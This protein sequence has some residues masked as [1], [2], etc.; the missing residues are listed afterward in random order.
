MEKRPRHRRL[1]ALI[2]F[3][4]VLFGLF[5]ARLFQ[6]Q[7]TEGSHYASLLHQNSSLILP[8]PASRGEILDRN[9]TPLVQNRAS[10]QVMI[11]YNYYPAGGGAAQ[12]AA[13]NGI[14]LELTAILT[15]AGEDWSDSLPLSREEPYTFLP[16]RDAGVAALRETLDLP[17]DADAANCMAALVT[18]YRLENFSQPEQRIAAGVQYEMALR[19]FG[20]LSPFL[21]ASDVSK[22]TTYTIGEKAADFPGV[23]IETA[24]V[25]DIVSGDTAPQLIG[26][27]GPMYAE[28]YARLKDKGYALNDTLGKSG[29]EAAF[30]SLL[31]GQSG[32]KELTKDPAGQVIGSKDIVSPVPGQTVILTL[33]SSLQELA[34][35]AIGDEINKLHKLSAK[36]GNYHDA[37]SGAAVM[38]DVKDGGVLAAAS[39]PNYDLSTYRQNYEE[40]AADPLKP[41]F[42][43]AL[44]G[45]YPCGSAMKPNVALAALTEEVIT[46]TSTVYCGGTYMYYAPGFEPKCLGHHGA[47]NVVKALTVSCNIFFYDTGRRLGI[48]KLDQYSALCGLGQKTGI[49]VGESAGTLAGPAYSQSV[50]KTWDD[51]MTTLAAIGQ[52][53]NQFTP[54]Q[55]AAY[56]MTIADGGTRYA[57]HLLSATRSYD[58]VLTP[59]RPTVAAQTGWTQEAMDTVQKGMV[60]VVKSGT[61]AS[62]FR[63]A[64][65]TVAGKT[66]TAQTGQA[67]RSDHGWFICYA[68]VENPRVALAVFLENG[69][70]HNAAAVARTILDGYFGKA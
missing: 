38:L 50:G 23:T 59:Y 30:E 21:F 10:Y 12:R 14:I 13:Q 8:L 7:I 52:S 4:A 32:Q 2:A 37:A 48:D 51:T 29:A 33:D 34:Q 55:M 31:R 45:A 47:L 39:W 27:V 5:G 24:A 25:R 56:A 18:R 57:T 41:L 68:P 44:Q 63:G 17:T 42:D 3:V 53:D 60:A 20:A 46:P 36:N 15:K 19:Q 11:D 61:A 9:L 64:T 58:G 6:L 67:G 70:S 54:I 35:N 65:Y 40:L 49:E 16:D 26:T 43:R 22:E 62:A 66:G 1:I 69:G 28:D